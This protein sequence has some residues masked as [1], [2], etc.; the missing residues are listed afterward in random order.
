MDITGEG[1]QLI[2]PEG[3]TDF[4]F[5]RLPPLPLSPNAVVLGGGAAANAGATAA[6]AATVIAPQEID[7]DLTGI[8][9]GAELAAS[10]TESDSDSDERG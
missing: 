10:E 7:Q 3:T 5:T 2:T 1:D 9:A 4:T 8:A 6:I